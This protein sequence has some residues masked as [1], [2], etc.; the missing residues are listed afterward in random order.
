MHW[1][2]IHLPP[3]AMRTQRIVRPML[4]PGVIGQ[5]RGPNLLIDG[6]AEAVGVGAWTASNA[7]LTKGTTEPI[8]GAQTLNVEKTGS[9]S[10]SARQTPLI[11]GTSY[12]LTGWVRTDG[13]VAAPIYDDGFEIF[14]IYNTATSW[15]YFDFTW[16]AR[17][18]ALR[19]YA[20][21]GGA[22]DYADWDDLYL[23]A[24]PGL[25]PNL[26][27]D[28]DMEAAYAGWKLAAGDGTISKISDSYEGAQAMRITRGATVPAAGRVVLTVGVD[29]RL[30]GVA[31]SCGSCLPRI[32]DSTY[33]WTGTT[34]TSWQPFDITW[35]AGNS[36]LRFYTGS[37][38]PGGFTDW[39]DLVLVEV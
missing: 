28:G 23:S 26:L 34:S 11:A 22:G 1:P 17:S 39:D 5:W 4:P 14:Y 37:G 10:A 33:R 32:Y 7:I 8:Q 35:T 29:Y 30:T 2:R 9:P 27:G 18:T 12:R 25:A 31:R 15:T 20:S 16:L 6:N 13:V 3:G 38:A 19:F 24:E 36:T 21:G